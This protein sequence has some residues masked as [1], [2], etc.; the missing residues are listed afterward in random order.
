MVHRMRRYWQMRLFA[1]ELQKQELM[2]VAAPSSTSAVLRGNTSRRTT[3]K[4]A[5]IDAHSVLAM[6]QALNGGQQSQTSP[7][8][9]RASSSAKPTVV[10]APPPTIRSESTPEKPKPITNDPWEASSLGATAVNSAV[11]AEL[12]KQAATTAALQAQLLQQQ[13]AQQQ[14]AAQQNQFFAAQQQAAIAAKKQ[15][16]QAS[17]QLQQQQAVALNAKRQAELALQQQQIE[18]QKVEAQKAAALNKMREETARLEAQLAEQRRI[19]AARPLQQPLIPT[20]SANPNLGFVPVS[21]QP[22]SMMG[23]L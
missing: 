2:G 22:M 11:A 3:A 17:A 1:R 6:K 14:L 23:E 16:E 18:A 7:P 13:Q 15:A 5:T 21:N 19:A 8:S 20:P 12:Q 9:I 10:Y 4:T